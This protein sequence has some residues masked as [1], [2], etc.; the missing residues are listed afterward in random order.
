MVLLVY[1]PSHNITA[2]GFERLHPFDGR[3]IPIG[4]GGNDGP[5]QGEVDRVPQGQYHAS[6]D[7]R[8]SP[9][10]TE[11]SG[12]RRSILR[13]GAGRTRRRSRCPGRHAWR[14]L[15]PALDSSDTSTAT[16]TVTPPRHADKGRGTR[17][18][19]LAESARWCP[20]ATPRR[21]ALD[22]G[23]PRR[24]VARDGLPRSRADRRLTRGTTPRASTRGGSR[25]KCV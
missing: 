8:P 3:K 7:Q 9:G 14:P 5:D 22:A 20:A 13:H 25:G 12:R 11:R 24:Y 4:T 21:A 6:G 19:P 18:L 17:V 1:H 16:R 2:F 23:G 15:C 10:G